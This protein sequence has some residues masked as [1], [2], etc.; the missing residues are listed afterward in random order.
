MY[1][2]AYMHQLLN[3]EMFDSMV[4]SDALFFSCTQMC[5]YILLNFALQLKLVTL[6]KTFV[7]L[8]VQKKFYKQMKASR[9]SCRDEFWVIFV[10]FL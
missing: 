9:F 4:E 5:I 8:G 7:M 1:A 3:A 10:A 6:F 2:H